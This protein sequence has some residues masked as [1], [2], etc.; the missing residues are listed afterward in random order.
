MAWRNGGT[1][2]GLVGKYNLPSVFGTLHFPR[3]MGGGVQYHGQ[4]LRGK[5]HGHGILYH[6]NGSIMYEGAFFNGMPIKRN[7]FHIG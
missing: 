5:E 3:N 6:T 7:P 4:F 1:Y 2:K